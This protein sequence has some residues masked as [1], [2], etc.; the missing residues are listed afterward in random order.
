MS[1]NILLDINEEI[2][3]DNIP[4]LL[5]DKDILSGLEDGTSTN[6]NSSSETKK[7]KRNP[8]TLLKNPMLQEQ[9]FFCQHQMLTLN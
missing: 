4:Q 8:I 7:I 3:K 5:H 1:E 2:D 9:R 6:S